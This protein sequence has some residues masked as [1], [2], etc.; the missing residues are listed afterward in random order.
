[1]TE[2]LKG[3][4]MA[5]PGEKV[6]GMIIARKASQKLLYALNAV[7][8]VDLQL[9]EVEFKLRQAPNKLDPQ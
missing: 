1:L 9:Y 2:K 6:Q 3:L 4:E 7:N 5:K 8:D